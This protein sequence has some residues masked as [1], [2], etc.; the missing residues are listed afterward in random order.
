[1]YSEFEDEILDEN[2]TPLKMCGSDDCEYNSDGFCC[3]EK[4]DECPLGNE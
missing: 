4:W 2:G 3:K 1:M